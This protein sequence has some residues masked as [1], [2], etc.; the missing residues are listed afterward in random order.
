MRIKYKKINEI[1]QKIQQDKFIEY[2]NLS[3]ALLLFND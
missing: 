1:R 2:Y 3:K